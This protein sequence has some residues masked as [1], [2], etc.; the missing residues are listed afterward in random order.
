MKYKSKV[1]CNIC[2]AN[3]SEEPNKVFIQATHKGEIV[4]ICTSCMPTIIHGS[5]IAI[6]SNDEILEE[7]K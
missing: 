5:G 1:Y 4:D 6:K 3:D 7:I 2:L